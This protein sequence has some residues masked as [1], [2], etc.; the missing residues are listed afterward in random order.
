MKKPPSVLLKLCDMGIITQCRVI[1]THDGMDKDWTHV[2]LRGEKYN[3]GKTVKTKKK[4]LWN[5]IEEFINYRI[6]HC[7]LMEVGHGYQAQVLEW[8]KYKR[9]NKKDEEEYKRLKAKFE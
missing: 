7:S 8:E 4:F 9:E 6:N 2:E 1:Y 3:G 5:K